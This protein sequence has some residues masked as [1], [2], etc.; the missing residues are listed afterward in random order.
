MQRIITLFVFL[1]FSSHIYGQQ[2][3]SIGTTGTPPDPSAILDLQSA[4]KGLLVPKVPL[5]AKNVTTPVV[6]PANTLLVYNTATA[7]TTPNNVM[8]G[9]YYWNQAA[10]E[11]TRIVTGTIVDSDNQNLT[12]ATLNGTIL[13]IGIQGGASTSVDLAS[14]LS[15]AGTD[16][17]NIVNFGLSG[18]NLTITIEDGNSLTTSLAPV[19]AN[20]GT[21]DQNIIG[22]TLSGTNLTIGIENGG[23]QTINLAPALAN[24]G[25]DDQNLTLGAGTTSTSI[26]NMEN[27]SDIT[28]QEGSNIQITESGNVM[29]I[30]AT[31]DGTGTDDQNITGSNLAGTN[32][33]IGIENGN[34]QTINLSSL[35][36]NEWHTNGNAGTNTNLQF[37]GTTDNVPLTFKVNNIQKLRLETNGTIRPMNN[38]RSVFL[39]E[40]AG[41]ND[42]LAIKRNVFI[43][44]YSGGANTTGDSNTSIGGNNFT[45]NLTGRRNTSAGAYAMTGN[46]SGNF[47]CALGYDALGD[48]T[49]GSSNV[50]IGNLALNEN[51]TGTNNVAVGGGSPLGNLTAGTRNIAVGFAAVSANGNAGGIP[52]AYSYVI[53]I[54]SST[55]V[56]KSVG[57]Y[58][59]AIGDNAC[60]RERTGS[61]NVGVGSN[62]IYINQSGDFN[63][64]IGHRAYS[65]SASN[66]ALTN[67]TAIGANSSINIS[68]K[69]RFGNAAVTVIEGQVAYSFP[70]DARFKEKIR[71]NVPGLDFVLGLRPVTYNFNTEK[72]T[73]FL[74]GD[75]PDSLRYDQGERIDYTASSNIRHTGFI[76]QEIEA[77]SKELN[78]DFDGVHI[79][80]NEHDNYSVSYSTFVVPLV[81]AVQE[82]NTIIE[83]LKEKDLQATTEIEDLKSRI[84][85]LEQLILRKE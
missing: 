60:S 70:S 36:D 79:P 77:L 45:N 32:L 74:L 13:Q 26:L 51:I 5:T 40:G 56:D 50:A 38:G 64:A 85:Q 43:G 27:G 62:A 23:S 22:S 42:N 44:Y 57:N 18:T 82:Q 53:G 19:L 69:I 33:T 46:I 66:I 29:T 1:M 14:V 24:A 37:L 72:F 71:E 54:G 41:L 2:G 67:S 65:T 17:Q 48:N 31:G 49:T 55:F 9:F 75:L 8:P 20:A 76:A 4:D 84:A 6:S 12:G 34:N 21:D 30:N 35:T 28:V 63:T 80:E 78:Y 25:T 61:G 16:D 11:W 59:V 81:K 3:V 83:S 47:N 39:G 10:G 73:D 68:N 52:A 58:S 15:T 7:G